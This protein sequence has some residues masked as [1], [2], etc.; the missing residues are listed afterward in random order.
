MRQV[1][2]IARNTMHNME[3]RITA[4]VPTAA[5]VLE[6]KVGDQAPY[7]FGTSTV[8]EITYRGVDVNG[9]AFV[10]Y[11][12]QFGENGSRMSASLKEDEMHYGPF[13]LNHTAR[14]MRDMEQQAA[15]QI[16][17]QKGEAVHV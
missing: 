12:V 6:L 17:A 14:Q 11:Y 7:I 4:I 8:V 5:D 2:V 15:R 13:T 10:G 3:T 16:A 1:E 9:K